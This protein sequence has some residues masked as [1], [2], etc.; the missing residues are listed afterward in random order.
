[1][2]QMN[3]CIVGVAHIA[4]DKPVMTN[5]CLRALLGSIASF[6][7]LFKFFPVLV[8][9]LTLITPACCL[10]SVVVKDLCISCLVPNGRVSG[11]HR[12]A[13]R[14]TKQQKEESCMFNGWPEIKLRMNM[15]VVL[16]SMDI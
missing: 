16:Y 10:T 13:F 11:A 9:W 12:G 7:F 15:T 8:F 3:M 4:C 6:S 1:M 5:L 14:S 2:D